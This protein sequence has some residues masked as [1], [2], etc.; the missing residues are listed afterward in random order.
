MSGSRTL[1]GPYTI[2]EVLD[3]DRDRANRINVPWP[4]LMGT[5][6]TGD[7]LAYYY[8]MPNVG[9]PDV[10]LKVMNTYLYQSAAGAATT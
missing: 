8:N 4:G 2:Q 6:D 1:D 3:F 9:T 5:T 7:K 10:R